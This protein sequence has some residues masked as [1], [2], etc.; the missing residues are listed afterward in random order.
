MEHMTGSV[1]DKICKKNLS[2]YDAMHYLK[3]AAEGLAYLHNR[4]PMPIIH[5]DIKCNL[6]T[7]YVCL[8][9]YCNLIKWSG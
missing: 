1:K 2:E 3:Q 7:F 9:Q 8:L 4:R 5:R 6:F